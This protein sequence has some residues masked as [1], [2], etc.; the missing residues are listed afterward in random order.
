ME[1]LNEC[2]IEQLIEETISQYEHDADD[3]ERGLEE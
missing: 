1:Q 2:E 3:F